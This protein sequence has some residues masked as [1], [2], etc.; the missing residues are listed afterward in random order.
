MQYERDDSGE[1]ATLFSFT[2]KMINYCIWLVYVLT[3]LFVGIDSPVLTRVRMVMIIFAIL[4]INLH[5]LPS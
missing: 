3:I 2:V 4:Y 5:Y 1:S